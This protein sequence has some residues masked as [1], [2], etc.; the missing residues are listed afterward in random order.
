MVCVEVVDG[1]LMFYVS[2]YVVYMVIV[3]CLVVMWLGWLMV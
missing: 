3:V 2:C 1:G